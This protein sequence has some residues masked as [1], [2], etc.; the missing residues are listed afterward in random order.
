[1]KNKFLQWLVKN[2]QSVSL[3]FTAFVIISYNAI[4]KVIGSIPL[5]SLD[6]K[7]NILTALLAAYAV[8]VVMKLNSLDDLKDIHWPKPR[9]NFS[10]F[11]EDTYQFIDH[12]EAGMQKESLEL[13][14]RHDSMATLLRL[15]DSTQTSYDA[16]NYY[17][18]GWKNGMSEFFEA[19][20]GAQNR[21]VKTRRCFILR[22]EFRSQELAHQLV[23]EM[24]RQVSLGMQVF[25]VE[26]N[27]LQRI[28]YY[29]KNPLRGTGLYDG[30]FLSYD[31]S[32][33]RHSE[34][35]VAIRVT[36]DEKEVQEKNPFP[37]IFASGLV[38]QY[39]KNKIELEKW[40]EII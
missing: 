7:I 5:L 29:R 14:N 37:H 20:R 26:E 31:T 2:W 18:G 8:N 22:T 39:P 30:K 3:L 33:V 28:P 15:M 19:N 11:T 17:L 1:M 32:I 21:G 27:E 40:L 13:N 9:K 38:K 4:A 23:G 16:M 36:W 6:S 24:D 25:F 35:P 10:E 34:T 12:L